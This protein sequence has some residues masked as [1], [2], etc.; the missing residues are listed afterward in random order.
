MLS[1]TFGVKPG[2]DAAGETKQTM[3]NLYFGFDSSVY[4]ELSTRKHDSS[5]RKRTC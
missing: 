4:L 2:L 3:L 1:V 5:T